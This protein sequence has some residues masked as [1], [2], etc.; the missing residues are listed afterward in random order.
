MI[1]KKL[2]ITQKSQQKLNAELEFDMT[3]L[4]FLM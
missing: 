4:S 1:L 2:N 3:I